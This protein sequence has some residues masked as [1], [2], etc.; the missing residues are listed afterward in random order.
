[1]ITIPSQALRDT[2]CTKIEKDLNLHNMVVVEGNREH[3]VKVVVVEPPLLKPDSTKECV[4]GIKAI[5][6]GFNLENGLVIL[7]P[8]QTA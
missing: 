1:M 6:K 2:I 3:G 4:T 7:R 5:L 8:R